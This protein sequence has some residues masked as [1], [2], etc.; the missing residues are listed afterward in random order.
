MHI[1]WQRNKVIILATCPHT[2][3]H[4]LVIFYLD[5]SIIK[6]ISLYEK[7]KILGFTEDDKMS[8]K[9]KEYINL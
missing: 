8:M 9:N 3:F 1:K 7:I 2:F 5:Y 6:G 4:K